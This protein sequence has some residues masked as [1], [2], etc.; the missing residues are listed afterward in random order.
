MQAFHKTL[1]RRRQEVGMGE[2]R[3]SQLLGLTIMGYYDLE[4]YEDEWRNVVPLYITMFACR[5]FEIDMLQ[6][7]PD[8]TGVAVGPNVLAR[9]V[10]KKRRETLG[11][12]VKAFADRC[13]FAPDFTSIVEA[14]GLV[15]YPFE[16]VRTV[17][18]VLGLDLKSFMRHGLL[19]P[20]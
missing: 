20:H 8:Q 15:L 5:I 4:A 9:N 19:A 12:S 18:E 2:G 14:D 11:L 1:R 3:A 16:V 7:V 13:G 6:F 10:I 17:C